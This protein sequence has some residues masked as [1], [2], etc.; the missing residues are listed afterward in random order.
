MTANMQ[1]LATVFGALAMFLYG[2]TLMSDGLR[3]TAGER[4]KAILGYMTRNRFFAIL[5]GTIITGLIQ[6]SSAT[7]VMT[8]GFVNAG[9]LSLTQAI[10]VVFGANIGTTV[11]GQLVSFNLSDIALPAVAVGVIGLMFSK[12]VVTRGA[13]RTV[14]GFGFLFFGMNMMTTELKVLAEMPRFI[15]FFSSFDCTPVNGHLPFGSV[16]GAIAVGTACTMIVQSSSATIGITIALATTGVIGV[17]TAVPIVLGDNIGTTITAALA[18]IGANANA[19]RTALAHALFNLIGTCLVVLS[20]TI[21]T[22]DRDGIAAPVFFHLVEMCTEGRGLMGENPGRYVAMA[23]SIFNVSNVI[24]LSAFIPLLARLCEK[25][26]PERRRSKSLNMLEPRLLAAPDLAISAAVRALSDMTRRATT[27]V[28][29][30]VKAGLGDAAVSDESLHTAEDEVDSQQLSIRDYLI[31]ISQR[32]LSEN[33]ARA[34]PEIV[35]CINDAE[36]ISDLALILSHRTAKGR[37][38]L[39]HDDRELLRNILHS[40][41]HLSRSTLAALKGDLKA[42]ESAK[43]QEQEVVDQIRKVNARSAANLH[44]KEADAKADGFI[45]VGVL[46]LIRDIARHLG[47]IASRAPQII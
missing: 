22:T 13:W 32:K 5:A 37:N 43:A 27:L 18:S 31:S 41:R 24:I 30:A 46:A 45:L 19:R 2:M 23:H 34:L 9:L 6:S 15:A 40:I 35:H 25:I 29:V 20:F 21:V 7:T 4:M 28:N 47:N 26:I 8:V 12:K 3:E 36:R 10:G 17:W 39:T 44:T 38:D 1:L 16:L 14:L 42:A 33:A 11:T